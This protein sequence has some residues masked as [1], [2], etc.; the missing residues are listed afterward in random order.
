MLV[1]LSN[2]SIE[3]SLDLRSSD[4]SNVEETPENQALVEWHPDEA[5]DGATVNNVGC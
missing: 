2:C 5:S 1:E 3:G 4:A